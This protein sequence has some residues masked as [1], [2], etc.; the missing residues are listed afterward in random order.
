MLA[1]L[2]LRALDNRSAEP[3][4]GD[5]Y[6]DEAVQRIDFDFGKSKMGARNAVPVA[7]RANALD[8]WV[9]EALRGGNCASRDSSPG[10][11]VLHL[12]CGLDSRFERTD[13]PEGVEWYDID[14]PDVIELRRRLFPERPH[15]HTIDRKS[16]V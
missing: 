11:T 8:R 16:V 15:H 7:M 12:G 2:Y 4:L 3:M 5:R 13:P 10:M 14:Q 6:A 9:E 1:T